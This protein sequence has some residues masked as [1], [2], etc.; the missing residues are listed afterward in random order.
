MK[1]NKC[2][3]SF[4]E[5]FSLLDEEHR[6]RRGWQRLVDGEYL[7]RDKCLRVPLEDLYDMYLE[8]ISDV[9]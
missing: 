8:L 3:Y 9:N 4:D 7:D 6:K 1:K 5:L 2:P